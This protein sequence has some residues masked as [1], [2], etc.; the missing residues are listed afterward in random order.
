MATIVFDELRDAQLGNPTHSVIDFDTDAIAS[1]LLD[2]TDANGGTALTASN[3]VDYA[4]VNDVVVVFDEEAHASQTVG[5]VGVGV[6]DAANLTMSSVTGDQADYLTVHK[7]TGT[8]TTSPLS[9]V[10]DSVTTG[11]PVLPN[12]GDI[13]TTWAG[14]GILAI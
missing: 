10:Y 14:G 9:H 3:V 2:A 6:Y 5:T 1:S 12:G 4:D 11:L 7:D 8:D 13:T